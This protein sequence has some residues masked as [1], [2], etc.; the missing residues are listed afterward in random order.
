[1]ENNKIDMRLLSYFSGQITEAEE[2]ELAKWLKE[3]ENNK[4]ILSEMADWWAIAHVPHFN[5]E[6]D[7]DKK[8][9]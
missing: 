6:I 1:M 2:I 5:K 4:K 8:Y 7:I 3:D 9:T